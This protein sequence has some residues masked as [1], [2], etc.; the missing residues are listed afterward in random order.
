MT[1]RHFARGARAVIA[2]GLGLLLVAM[3]EPRA[4]AQPNAATTTR[5][6]LEIQNEVIEN[7]LRQPIG[8]HRVADLHLSDTFVRRV[9][10]RVTREAYQQRFR[11]V[12]DD[13]NASGQPTTTQS[14]PATT[15]QPGHTAAS[16]GPSASSQ[17]AAQPNATHYPITTTRAADDPFDLRARTRRFYLK[18]F[19]IL[20]GVSVSY[21][22][23]RRGARR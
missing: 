9:A 5:P 4:V 14:D 8:R 16:D 1:R 17:A 11:I 20:V 19:I 13:G 6:D 7:I 18:F 2:A 12:V 10:D 15:S 21:A 23:W 22:L 3:Y